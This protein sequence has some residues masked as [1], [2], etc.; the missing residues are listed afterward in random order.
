ML[1]QVSKELYNAQ[2]QYVISF[3]EEWKRI[4][5]YQN[6]PTLTLGHC[7]ELFIGVSYR[8]RYEEIL[9]GVKNYVLEGDEFVVAHDGKELIEVIFYEC[10]ET[11]KKRIAA[12]GTR[13]EEV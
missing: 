1:Q 13:T 8:L 12:S 9:H 6:T 11:L 4:K 7:I 5:H 3:I 2:P 10:V